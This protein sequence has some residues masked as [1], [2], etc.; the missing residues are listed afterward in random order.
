MTLFG[1]PAVPSAGFGVIVASKVCVIRMKLTSVTN[2]AKNDLA[3][4]DAEIIL[5]NCVDTDAKTLEIQRGYG[6]TQAEEHA[7]GSLVWIDKVDYFLQPTPSGYADE[8]KQIVLP[9]PALPDKNHVP[10]L[11]RPLNGS[12]VECP[13][14][15]AKDFYALDPKTGRSPLPVP[16]RRYPVAGT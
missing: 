12:W 13:V 11:W 15:R 10:M 4:I 8:A 6:G 5:V 9:R 14:A 1:R 16:A 2:R 7:N 3:L